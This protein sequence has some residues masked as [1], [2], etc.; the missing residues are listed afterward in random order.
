MVKEWLAAHKSLATSLVSGTLIVAV[1]VTTAIVSGGYSAQKINLNDSSVWVANGAKEL[2]GRVNTE[3]NELNSIV[4]TESNELDVIQD[5]STVLLFDQGSS[6]ASIIDPATST[7]TDSVPM[8]S[9]DP[10]L[11]IAGDNVVVADGDG[12][13]WVVPKADFRHFDP[14]APP[15][16]TL[17]SRA[18]YSMS[19]SGTL[20]AYSQDAQLLYLIDTAVSSSVVESHSVVFGDA[21]SSLSV[22]TV[23]SRW[24]ILDATSRSLNLNGTLVDLSKIIGVGDLPKIQLPSASG[25][26]VLVGYAGSLLGI[27]FSGGPV[28]VKVSGSSGSASL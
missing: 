24:A 2:I 6:K 18:T 13:V 5:G 19:E 14:Q 3:I 8:P 27:P 21:A 16:L 12:D 15:T 7:I 1:A 4:P 25:D 9:N 22:T 26:S 10:K 23:G 17:G 11:F 20:V 28:T